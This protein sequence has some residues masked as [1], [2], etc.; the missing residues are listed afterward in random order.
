MRDP[1]LS[2]IESFIWG[3]T[4]FAVKEAIHGVRKALNEPASDPGRDSHIGHGISPL[5][6]R[7][8]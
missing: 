2:P 3:H 8:V 4:N 1:R 7:K 5:K 6:R